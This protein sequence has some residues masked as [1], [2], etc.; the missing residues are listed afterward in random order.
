MA[1]DHFKDERGPRCHAVQGL[2]V[3]SHHERERYCRTDGEGRCPTYR[4]FQLRRGPIS[5]GDYYALWFVPQAPLPPRSDAR[6][7]DEG[8]APRMHTP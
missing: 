5:Q 4:L 8:R 3:P 1:C 2:L 6:A 7:R